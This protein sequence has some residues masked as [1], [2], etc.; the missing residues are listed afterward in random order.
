MYFKNPI[1]FCMCCVALT[2]Y[3]VLIGIQYISHCCLPVLSVRLTGTLWSWEQKP[4]AKYSFAVQKG[5]DLF[6]AL[7]NYVFINVI[8]PTIHYIFMAL[9]G[10]VNVVVL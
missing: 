6:N 3:K 9:L 4:F 7:V 8:N 5:I 1:F 10:F 2:E